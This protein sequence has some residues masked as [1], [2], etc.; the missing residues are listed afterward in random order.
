[1]S[2]ERKNVLWT[3]EIRGWRTENNEEDDDVVVIVVM[4]M[5]Q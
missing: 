5:R 2:L 1:V 3:M 4:M